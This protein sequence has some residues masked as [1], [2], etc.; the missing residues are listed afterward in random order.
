MSD[1]NMCSKDDLQHQVDVLLRNLQDFEPHIWALDHLSYT[2]DHVVREMMSCSTSESGQIRANH[3][4]WL[5]DVMLEYLL[6]I[7]DTAKVYLAVT[8][9]FHRNDCN[10]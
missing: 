6:S 8:Y 1:G 7:A 9:K 10:Y 2:M 3:F 5:V 4:S